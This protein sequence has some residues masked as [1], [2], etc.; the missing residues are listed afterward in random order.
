ML[1][2]L[3]TTL[4]VLTSSTALATH[5]GKTHMNLPAAATDSDFY[6][7]GAPSAAKVDLGKKLF[8]DK[9][10][11]GNKNDSCATCHHSLTDTGDGLSLP[12]GEGARGLGVTRDTGTGSDAI[13]ER[14]P[15]NAPPVFNLGAKEYVNLFHDGRV[16]VGPNGEL[17]T[18]AGANLPSDFDNILAAQA[19]F[20]VTSGT[21]MAGQTGENSIADAAAA[22]NL[23]GPGGVWEQLA[24]RLQGV[25]AYV[26]MFVNTFDDVSSASDITYV[27]AANA[28]SAFEAK[29]WRATNSPFDKLLNG[30]LTALSYEAIK[31]CVYFMVMQDVALVTVV[32]F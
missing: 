1:G 18:P 8:F 31:E 17:L 28:I 27:H 6:D 13:H 4:I 5:R 16:Q 3:S 32:P 26:N 12:V 15:S 11:S 24:F 20:P 9:I 29:N 2:I 10:L 30:D 25:P 7:N 23:A 14:V 21:E 19:M 22:G